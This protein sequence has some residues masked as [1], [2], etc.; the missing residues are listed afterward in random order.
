MLDGGHL[1]IE[2]TVRH[3][4]IPRGVLGIA[5]A[6][7][8][9]LLASAQAP[10]FLDQGWSK[11]IRELYYF[12]PQGS[13]MIPYAWFMA[14]ETPDGKGMFADA[15]HLRRYGLIPADEPHP[16]NPDMLPIGFA[17]DPP[18]APESDAALAVSPNPTGSP[19]QYL[20]LTCAACH[21]ATVTVEGRPIRIDGGAANFDFDT[22]YADL[23]TAVTRTLFDPERFQR[24]ASRVLVTGSVTGLPD[25]QLQ[26]AAFQA[27]MAGEAVIRRPTLISGFGRVDALTQIVNALAATDQSAPPNLRAVD[28]PTSYPPL[29]L[30]PE[31]EFVQ[32]NPIAGSPIG[33][34][35]GE[36]LGVF[37]TASLSGDPQGWF[38]SS[39]L[40]KQLHALETWVA[41][42]KP[43]K[44]DEGIFGPINKDVTAKGDELFRQFCKGCH[45]M[46][47]YSRT[48]PAANFF[49]KTFIEIGRV[50]YRSTG[51]DT[52]YVEFAGTTPGPHQRCNCA[53]TRQ[54]GGGAGRGLFPADGRRDHQQGHG[55]GG[56][57]REGKNCDRWLPPAQIR[58]RSAGILFATVAHRLEGQPAGRDL[59]DRTVS[60]QWLCADRLRAVVAGAGAPEGV[61]DRRTRA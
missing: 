22:F 9:P 11:Q 56:S 58:H 16:L 6:S 57:V 1:T 20:G 48:D 30:T 26:F 40:L 10:T 25:L 5:I 61:L 4:L 19:G 31:L 39:I 28:A 12:T 44:W 15:E 8:L 24:F 29:W 43:P 51:T 2:G 7:V 23:A 13:R 37:G 47:P 45:N 14:L 35:G 53:A 3:R 46:A 27:R 42:L 50:P 38:S 33:R 60:P 41:D 18:R 52:V 17:I 59:G 54:Q 34:N 21:T 55:C 49:G 32:W 36:V